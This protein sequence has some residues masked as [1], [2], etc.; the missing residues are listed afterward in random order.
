MPTYGKTEIILSD[1]AF[2]GIV[3]SSIEVYK[4][5]C[6]GILLGVKSQGKIVVEHAIPLQAITKRTFREVSP[7]WKKTIKLK[8]A[9][10]RLMHLEHIGDFHSHT[11]WG[12]VKGLAE[13]SDA[14]KQSME[15]TNIEIVAA[16]NNCKHRTSWKITNGELAGSICDYNIR[17]VGFYKKKDDVI[18]Q[19]DIVCPY[20][21]GCDAA[22]N[23]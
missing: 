12:D 10:P 21:V 8:E 1:K 22:F 14:D 13:L 15:S 2:Q 16:I 3:L 23:K 7:N 17:L 4:K 9:I 19:L 6:L 20:A 11:Q 18:K 5:E